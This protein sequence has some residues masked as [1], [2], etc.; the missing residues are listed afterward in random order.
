M[1]DL[2]V[3]TYRVTLRRPGGHTTPAGHKTCTVKAFRHGDAIYQA[4]CMAKDDSWFDMCLS[5]MQ[6][7]KVEVIR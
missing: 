3:V 2:R 6:V 1:N 5:D 4:K 7:E